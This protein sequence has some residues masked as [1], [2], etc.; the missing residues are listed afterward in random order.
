MSVPSEKYG[1]V[2][3]VTY[4][5]ADD[6]DPTHPASAGPKA[7]GIA[8]LRVEFEYKGETYVHDLPNG[9]FD[10]TNPALHIL[11]YAG[12]KPSDF[13]GQSL[14][15][16]DVR[17]PLVRNGKDDY[18]IHQQA[19]T[20]GAERLK[21][22]VWSPSHDYDEDSCEIR[23]SNVGGGGNDDDGGSP[24]RGDV[25]ADSQVEVPEGVG[26]DFNSRGMNVTVNE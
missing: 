20:T 5:K 21:E 9:E 15:V 2:Q 10:M 23:N 18:L 14:D 4:T 3:R 16:G 11:A 1:T 13:D 22:V 6:N 12:V 8:V 26:I 24:T 7:N 19:L 17:V 25:S